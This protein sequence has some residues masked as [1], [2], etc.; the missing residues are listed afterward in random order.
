MW[1]TFKHFRASNPV[2]VDSDRVV[3]FRSRLFTR[4]GYELNYYHL[5][6]ILL[7]VRMDFHW[8]YEKPGLPI[9]KIPPRQLLNVTVNDFD[10]MHAVSFMDFVRLSI[11]STSIG[12]NSFKRTTKGS[13]DHKNEFMNNSK[14]VR[15]VPRFVEKEI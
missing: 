2:G 9:R 12:I 3:C 4:I 6:P 15:I 10:S 11:N 8:N 5:H 13:L 1:T 14:D 7:S